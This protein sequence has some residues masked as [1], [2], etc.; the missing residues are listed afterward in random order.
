MLKRR[1]QFSEKQEEAMEKL[2]SAYAIDYKEQE[3][4]PYRTISVVDKSGK[5]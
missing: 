2:Q 5:G 4:R 1:V 3:K